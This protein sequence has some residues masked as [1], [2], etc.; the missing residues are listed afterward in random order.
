MKAAS[1][2]GFV[3]AMISLDWRALKIFMLKSLDILEHG[4]AYDKNFGD[5]RFRFLDACR[6]VCA[7]A[8]QTRLASLIRRLFADSKVAGLLA[9]PDQAPV[10]SPDRAGERDDSERD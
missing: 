5:F 1:V 2:D 4:E 6:Q 9:P 10:S 7:T 8:P 3:T